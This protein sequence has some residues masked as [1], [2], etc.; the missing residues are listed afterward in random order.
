MEDRIVNEPALI[1]AMRN[2]DEFTAQV[3]QVWGA[4]R[5]PVEAQRL[6][7]RAERNHGED[8][9]IMRLMMPEVMRVFRAELRELGA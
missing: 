9:K 7:G 5:G 8:I 1:R 2:Q 6:M 4:D 3:V